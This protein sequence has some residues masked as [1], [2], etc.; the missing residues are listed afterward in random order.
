MGTYVSVY[1]QDGEVPEG[2]EKIK[3]GTVPQET[4]AGSLVLTLDDGKFRAVAHGFWSQWR[5]YET[6]GEDDATG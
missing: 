3:V 5:V 6:R 1:D 4:P 2:I